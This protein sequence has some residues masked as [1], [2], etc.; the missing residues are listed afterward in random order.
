[1]LFVFSDYVIWTLYYIDMFFFNVLIKFGMIII[2]FFSFNI[3]FSIILY[4]Y[5]QIEREFSIKFPDLNILNQNK[6]WDPK[7]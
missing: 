4:M 3:C 7:S 6:K 2:V 1:L 5:A